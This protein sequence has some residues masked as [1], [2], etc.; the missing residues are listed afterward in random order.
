MWNFGTVWI[1]LPLR[2]DWPGHLLLLLRDDDDI[3][4]FGTVT[5]PTAPAPAP[6]TASALPSRQDRAR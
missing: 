4:S 1:E 5:C 3:G 6:A 2:R